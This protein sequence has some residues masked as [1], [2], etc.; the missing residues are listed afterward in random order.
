[1]PDIVNLFRAK[2]TELIVMLL[3][4]RGVIGHPG[5]KGSATEENWRR[6]LRSY[7]PTRYQ[8]A[9][10][11]VVDVDG[12]VSDQIDVLILDNQYTPVL[13]E[14]GGVR[15]FAAESLYAAFEVKQEINKQNIQYASAKLS[16]IRKLRRTSAPIIS[17]IGTDEPDDPVEPQRII[18]GLLTTDSASRSGLSKASKDHL[19]NLA[20]QSSLDIGCSITRGAFR[21]DH[22]A[23]IPTVVESQPK[24]SLV[25]F[26]LS[27]LDMLQNVGTVAA[28]DYQEWLKHAQ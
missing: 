14:S 25:F 28:I 7:L 15:Y 17:N 13:F 3:G 21:V 11:F 8:V 19:M 23:S 27:L 4:G 9:S 5:E 12:G 2:Q 26:M 18:G 16:S 10:G 22:D 20:Y 24:L 1:M 6:L